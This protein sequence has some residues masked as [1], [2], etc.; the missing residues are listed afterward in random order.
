MLGKC[1]YCGL[2]KDRHLKSCLTINQKSLAKY[3]EGFDSARRRIPKL[4]STNPITSKAGAML[5]EQSQRQTTRP[6]SLRRVRHA[7]PLLLYLNYFL[8]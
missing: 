1:R 4:E 8:G 7:G 6:N 2:N 3:K 5:C